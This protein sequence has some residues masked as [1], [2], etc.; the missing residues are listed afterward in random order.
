MAQWTITEIIAKVR[1]V[2]ATSVDQLDDTAIATYVNNYY[3]FTMPF[4]LKEQVNLEPL[5]FTALPNIDVYSF[6]GAFLTDQPMAYADGFPLVFYQ[7]RDI[8]FQD[9]P[10]QYGT[11]NVATGDGINPTFSSSTQAI[12]V[13]PKSFIITDGTQ[14]LQDVGSL[15]LTEQIAT[16]DGATAAYNG[17]LNQFPISPTTLSITDG[18]EVFS[19]NGTGVLIGSLGGAGTIVYATGVYSVTFNSNVLL[20]VG[21]YASYSLVQSLGIL[22]G[23]G[24]GSINYVTGAFNVTFNAPPASSATIYDKYQAYEPARPQGVLFYNNVFT[25][26]PIP[27]QVYAITM[28]G[29]VSQTQLSSSSPSPVFSEWGELI[30]FGAALEIFLDRGD[31]V[32]Y[33][34]FYPILKRY[35]NV[36]LART[37]QQYDA[38][39]S[40]PRF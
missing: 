25:F 6:P 8:F 16:G 3:A 9:W 12:P 32:A 10:Q 15:S 2:T 4:E 33:A 18:V 19:D 17:I 22:T 5:N 34:N 13:I 31:L 36:A 11:D 37:V 20:G 28:Q 7:D 24:A 1:N 35:E 21:I 29:Y 26:R 39:Q 30:A 23:D 14:V 38:Q 27:D 40:V